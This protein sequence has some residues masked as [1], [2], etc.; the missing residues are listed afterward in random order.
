MASHPPKLVTTTPPPSQ[1]DKMETE[2]GILGKAPIPSSSKVNN[3]GDKTP[4]NAKGQTEATAQSQSQSQQKTD[5]ASAMISPLV[6]FNSFKLNSDVIDKKRVA[7]KLLPPVFNANPAEVDAF[8]KGHAEH[9]KLALTKTA[10]HEGYHTETLKAE[11][12]VLFKI[13]DATS[14]LQT[15]YIGGD[16]PFIGRKLLAYLISNN[17]L[18]A[19]ERD[20]LLTEARKQLEEVAKGGEFLAPLQAVIQAIT[21]YRENYRT[22][23]QKT[24]SSRNELW[25]K[26][27]ECQKKLSACMLQRYYSP[28][29]FEPLPQFNVEPP[30][31]LYEMFCGSKK[32]VK[33]TKVLDHLG[34][35]WG[36]ASLPYPIAPPIMI[37]EPPQVFAKSTYL[38]YSTEQFGFIIHPDNVV[39]AL[40]KGEHHCV[41]CTD[42]FGGNGSIPGSG[43][44]RILGEDC[45]ALKRLYDDGLADLKQTIACL[46]NMD[47]AL[48]FLDEGKKPNMKP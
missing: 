42:S 43:L 48:K 19:K 35:I 36:S 24:S 20:D 7:E 40:W 25:A 14:A 37:D 8:F 10:Y 27:G 29:P 28:T 2:G 44:Y 4:Q 46:Q 38:H 47:S 21:N 17:Q 5:A 41:S 22:N 6:C 3:D 12:F 18:T 39:R 1:K 33:L 45:E 23:C 9:P 15:A 11:G 31:E 34:S 30:R 13:W 16:G 32:P 26:I